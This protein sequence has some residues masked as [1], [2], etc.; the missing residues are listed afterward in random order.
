MHDYNQKHNYCY[1][2]NNEEVQLI[3]IVSDRSPFSNHSP[4]FC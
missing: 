3:F 1:D 4:V 2:S